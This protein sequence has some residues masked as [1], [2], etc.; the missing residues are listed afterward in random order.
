[1]E[2]TF[3]FNIGDPVWIMHNNIAVVGK[4]K[5]MWYTKF[6]SPVNYDDICEAESYGLDVNGTLV[7]GIEPKQ[8]FRDKKDLL[9]SL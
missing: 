9:K 3:E 5:T 2:K 8:M 7:T 1:M 6:L 4:I